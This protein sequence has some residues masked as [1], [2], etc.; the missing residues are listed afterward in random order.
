ML[1]N[2]SPKANR[3][4]TLFDAQGGAADA[5]SEK[6]MGAL[7]DINRRY[8]RGVLR[9]A[10]EGVEK[11]WQMRRGNLSPSYTTSWCGLP[12]VRAK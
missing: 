2:L 8:G 7:D 10:A 4:L 9:L 3:Q 6:L 11:T 5:R 12:V 1:L